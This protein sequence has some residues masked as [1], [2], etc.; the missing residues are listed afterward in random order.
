MKLWLLKPVDHLPDRNSPWFPG[1]DSVHG[2]VIRASSEGH[3][4]S[5]ADA[6]AG[7]ENAGNGWSGCGLNILNKPKHPWL[8]S[9]LSDCVE[10]TADGKE[11]V[12]LKDYWE[13]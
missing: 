4:R 10:L 7:W 8:D 5:I 1:H 2:F 9:K 13:E 11:E 6:N 3:A 12:I